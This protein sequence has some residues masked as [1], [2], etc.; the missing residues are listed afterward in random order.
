MYKELQVV[1]HT[2]TG[3]IAGFTFLKLKDIRSAHLSERRFKPTEKLEDVDLT[4]KQMEYIYNDG[5]MLF[6][7]DPAA[8]EQYSIPKQTVGSIDRFL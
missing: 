8:Y 2:G 7:M 3:K 6:F 1:H 5:E 4:K